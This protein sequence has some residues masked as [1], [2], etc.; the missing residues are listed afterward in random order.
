[1][2]QKSVSFLP[3]CFPDRNIPP[4]KRS[5]TSPLP[6]LP[7]STRPHLHSLPPAVCINSLLPPSLSF[8][9]VTPAHVLSLCGSFWLLSPPKKAFGLVWPRGTT[10]GAFS[11]HRLSELSLREW[12]C[13]HSGWMTFP[14][15]TPRGP[16]SLFLLHWE[17]WMKCLPLEM[18]VKDK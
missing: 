3:R 5:N 8:G 16:I 14:S 17:N 11:G 15:R 10:W 4:E 9:L 2:E 13:L 6:V 12:L 18:R 7:S 1:M